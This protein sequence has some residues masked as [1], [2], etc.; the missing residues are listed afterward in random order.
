MQRVSATAALKYRP[1]YACLFAV[2][3]RPSADPACTGDNVTLELSP[4]NR[5]Q[6]GV[7]L[8]NSVAIVLWIKSSQEIVTNYSGRVTFNSS[9]GTLSLQSV[10]VAESGVY[11]VQSFSPLFRATASLT[12]L[13]PVSNVTVTANATNLVE[14][15]DTV[16][17]QCNSQGTSVTFRWL[18]GTSDIRVG[19]RVQLSDDNQ[20][21]TISNV[22]TSDKGPFYCLVSNAISNMTSEPIRFNINGPD[23]V[24]LF[25]NESKT[26]IFALGSNITLLCSADS[27]P[28]AEFQWYLNGASLHH[29]GQELRLKDAQPSVASVEVKPS[30]NPIA[31][32]QDVTFTVNPWTSIQVGTW[33]HGSNVI[34]LC[35]RVQLSNENRTLTISGVL[36]SDT[37]PLYCMVSNGISNGTSQLIILNIRYGPSDL[38]LT[39]NPHAAAY[40]AGSDLTL[41]CSSQ[42]NPPALYRWAFEGRFLDQKGSQLILANVHMNQTGNYTCWAYNDVTLRYTSVSTWATIIDPVSKVTINVTGELPILNGSF[43]LSCSVSGPVTFIQWLKDGWPLS[44]NNKTIFSGDNSSVTFSL[45]ELSDNG[46]YRCEASNAVSNQTSP[47]YKLLVNY[48][49]EQPIITGPNVAETGSVITF[50][51]TASSRPPS[52]YSWFF[53]GTQVAQG[54]LFKSGDLT[55]GSSGKYTC[56]AFNPVTG[57]SSSAV[58]E[59]SVVGELSA[60][61]RH[62]FHWLKGGQPLQLDDHVVLKNDNSSVL[63]SPALISDDGNYQ[64]VASNAFRSKI[65]PAYAL[66]V[67]FGPEAPIVTGLTSVREGD[68]V[69]LACYALSQPPSQYYW[70]FDN[71]TDSISRDSKMTIF[72]ARVANQGRYTCMARNTLLNTTSSASVIL[73]VTSSA[74]GPHHFSGGHLTLTL[75]L[76]G[77]L[78][79]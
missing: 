27:S 78:S 49:P 2:E 75:L 17:L 42:S 66:L 50:N 62:I 67:N 6:T 45:V 26:D 59:L 20:T 68:T 10:T 65:S 63:F 29:V 61:F 69:I 44:P 14:F 77:W 60:S 21:L 55:L 35:T 7:C 18:N 43:A 71:N 5:T 25:I 57:R 11:E 30:V 79:Y 31:V 54:P 37:G 76:I 15:N 58:K 46:N 33:S 56:V 12:V 70:T 73:D 22:L 53:N 64:C 47:E 39:V 9:I 38:T 34:L 36:R 52:Q 40:R 24:H 48:G 19:E 51:C 74:G 41:S 32:G 4:P 1:E 28:P 8:F 23:N 16:S 72:Y 13:D 3:F